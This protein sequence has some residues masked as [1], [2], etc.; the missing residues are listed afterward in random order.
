MP[1]SALLELGKHVQDA[2]EGVGRLLLGQPGSRRPGRKPRDIKTECMLEVVALNKGSF[3]VVLDVPR[4]AQDKLEGMQLGEEAAET[5]VAGLHVLGNGG[6]ALPAG[7]DGGVLHSVRDIGHVLS[8]G[9]ESIEFETRKGKTRRGTR[10]TY[11]RAFRES[12]VRRIREPIT[13]EQSVEG[14]LLMADF[15]LSSRRCR[16]HQ[17]SGGTVECTFGQEMMDTVQEFLR[18]NVRVTGEALIDADTSRIK[19]LAISDIEPVT[20]GE[21]G[22]EEITAEDFWQEKSI[23]Q[24]AEEQGV[25]PVER[26]EDILGRHADLWGSDEE[27]EAFV[28]G[29]YER[30]RR[31]VAE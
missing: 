13:N 31:E 5:F 28:S 18:R 8:D 15:K 6:T 1:L 9:I 10:H 16:V 24:L 25:R 4:P 27:F 22:F 23:D 11:D 12:I 7:Y 19:R 20:E 2:V 3:E 21:E 29:I 26:L 30:R 14:R 17:P